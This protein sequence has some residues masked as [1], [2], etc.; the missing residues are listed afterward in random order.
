MTRQNQRSDREQDS[1]DSEDSEAGNHKNL[2]RQQSDSQYEQN[3]FQSTGC[4]AKKAAPE[5]KR[6]EHGGEDGKESRRQMEFDIDA[7]D[8]Q[9]DQQKAANAGIQHG[10]QR[11]DPGTGHWR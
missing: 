1:R 10:N 9:R 11:V 4:T 3:Q 6:E 5:K 8:A 7:D 2:Q